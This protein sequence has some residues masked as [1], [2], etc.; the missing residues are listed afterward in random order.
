MELRLDGENGPLIGTLNVNPTGAWD[1]WKTQSCSISGANGVHDLYL[2][3]TG[4]SSLL[5]NFDCW[6]FEK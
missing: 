3:F 2:N 4:D 5:M 1:N 6:K